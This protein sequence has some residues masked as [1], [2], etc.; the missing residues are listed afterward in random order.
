MIEDDSEKRR[1]REQ[2]LHALIGSPK[3]G[4]PPPTAA[5]SLVEL[6]KIERYRDAVF[7]QLLQ[8]AKTPETTALL[9]DYVKTGTR[10]QA[11]AATRALCGYRVVNL[12]DLTAAERDRVTQTGERAAGQVWYWAKEEDLARNA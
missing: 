8:I 4:A 11:V 5:R 7:F 10:E 1:I 12:G 9:R 6:A 2:A 3:Y